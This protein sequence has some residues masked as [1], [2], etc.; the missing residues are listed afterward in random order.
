MPL[1]CPPTEEMRKELECGCVFLHVHNTSQGFNCSYCFQTPA[2][3]IQQVTFQKILTDVSFFSIP[4]KPACTFSFGCCRQNAQVKGRFHLQHRP[5]TAPGG[6]HNCFANF[7]LTVIEDQH[8][9]PSG[10]LINIFN[11]KK[12]QVTL[13]SSPKMKNLLSDRYDTS[14]YIKMNPNVVSG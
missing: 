8:C 5:L 2:T 7:F 12:Y 14:S 9:C 13:S 6:N 4:L 1:L 11:I 10:L 3:V